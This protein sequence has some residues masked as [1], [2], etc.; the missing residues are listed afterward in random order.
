MKAAAGALGVAALGTRAGAHNKFG[1]GTDGYLGDNVADT[2][3]RSELVG[4]HSAGGVG[5][6]SLSGQP[7][8]AHVGGMTELRV[9]DDLA[10]VTMFSDTDDDTQRGLAILEISDFTRAES[11]DE[12]DGADLTVLS[13]VRNDN[14]ESACMDVKVSDDGDYVFVC[15]QPLTALFGENEDGLLSTDDHSTSAE[16]AALLAVDVSDPGNPEVVD[17]VSISRWVLG[18]HNCWHH[19]IGGEEYVFTAHGA[20]GVSGSMN[21]F[22]FERGTDQLAQ[23]NTWTW[24]GQE[25]A[26]DGI[27]NPLQTYAHD[28]VV[29]EDPRYGIPIAYLGYLDAGTRILDVSDP[30]DIEELGVFESQ[31]AHH[32]VPAPTLIDGKRVMVVGHENPDSD[33]Q[34]EG[35]NALNDGET[36]YYYLVDGDPLDDVI[37]GDSEP[38]YL[39]AASILW[40]ADDDLYEPLTEPPFEMYRDRPGAD[41]AAEPRELDGWILIDGA[42]DEGWGDAAG[43][44]AEAERED[45]PDEKPDEYDG[46][47]NFRLSPH[48][49]DVDP[50]GR[51]YAGHYHAGARIYRI[52]APGDPLPAGPDVEEYDDRFE[53]AEPGDP[54][55]DW[56]LLETA[57]YRRGK[58]I[59]EERTMSGGGE[60]GD[61]LTASTPF[62]WCLVQRNG[63][64]FAGG[65]NGGP[66]VVHEDDVPVGEDA[67]VDAAVSRDHDASAVTAGQTHRITIAVESDENVR[68]RDAIPLGWEVVGGDVAAVRAVDGYRQVVSLDVD[69]A[70]GEATY[71]VEAP[72]KTGTDAFGPVEYARGDVASEFGGGVSTTNRLWRKAN[73]AVTETTVIELDTS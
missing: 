8:D 18:P 33:P 35:G 66:H 46:F 34:E 55:D 48:N 27:E 63:V 53:D 5:S 6:A 32:T 73:A 13:F 16:A 67:P 10:F 71:Y 23:A 51:I 38:V 19:Q 21:V 69:D 29:Q 50:D 49:L 54:A 22:A 4:Y 15:K 41:P 45:D 65:I 17:S 44:E 25:T 56:Y 59:P 64:A 37:E 58:E 20:D 26:G 28:V 68:V 57:Y 72:E 62:F 7:E 9:H 40:N 47:G 39:G 52:V 12:L 30:T 14:T 60:L 11:E 61:G 70:S 43:F 24:P 2:A 36:G 31:R 1:G 3:V 42:A